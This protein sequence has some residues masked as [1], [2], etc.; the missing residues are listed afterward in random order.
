MWTSQNSPCATPSLR[1]ESYAHAIEHCGRLTAMTERT[2]VTLVIPAWNEADAIGAVLDEVPDALVD[3]VLVV[4]GGPTDPTATVAR[5]HGARVLVQLEPGYGAAC[6]AG[7]KVALADGA[8]MVAFLDGDYADPPADLAR[9]LAPLRAGR[10]DLVLGCRDLRRFPQALPLH[11]R[12]G[13]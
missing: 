7:A 9:I 4:V 3:Q 5:L 11:A 1:L 10:A 13:N 6:S 2:G 8:Q 12:F